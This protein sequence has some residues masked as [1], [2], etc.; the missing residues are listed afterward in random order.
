M[1]PLIL[2]AYIFYNSST[3]VVP[4]RGILLPNFEMGHK[5]KNAN[6][7]AIL[8]ERNREAFGKK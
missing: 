3:I 4:L 1:K 7:P 8:C 2:Y 6:A 5:P